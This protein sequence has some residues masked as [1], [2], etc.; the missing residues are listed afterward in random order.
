M[1]KLRVFQWERR[2]DLFSGISKIMNRGIV[3][4][5]LC[6]SVVK[7]NAQT[8]TGEPAAIPPFPQACCAEP[9]E[10]P[11]ITEINRQPS[12]VTAYSY[13]NVADAIEDNREKS[14]FLLLN[15][16]WN[17]KLVLK[18]AD[19]PSDFFLSKVNNWETIDVPSNWEMKG[20]DKPIY[21]SS[22]YPF[23]PIDPPY[24]PKDYNAVGSYQRTFTVPA[25]W[26]DMT[27]TLHFGGVSSG[28]KVW[29]N[30]KFVGYGED[31]CLPS[32]FIVNPYL[33]DGENTVSVQVIR[34]A[35]GVYLEDQDHWRMSG[36][37]REVFLMAEP[38]LRIADFFWQAKLDKDYK[39]A[40]LSIRP[41]LENLTGDTVRGCFIKAQLYD[42]NNN[43]VLA[44]PLSRT[45]E[46]LINEFYPRLDN[47]KFGALET[48]IKNPDKWSDEAPNL[49]TLV[50]T[51]ED[52][53][54]RIL[55]TKS[56]KVGFRSI[57]FSKKDS[58]LLINGKVTY[59]Y[60]IN[61]HDHNPVNGKALT[62]ADIEKDVRTIKQFNFNCIRTAHYPN[63]PY[64]YDLCD[65]YGILVMDEANRETHGLG[66]KLNNTDQWIHAIMERTTRMVERDKNHPCVIMW[67][68][69]NE[70]G[71]GPAD[72]AAA[73]WVH[74]FDITRPVHYEPAQGS[75]AV[76]GYIA[77]GEPG[78]PA[79][80][81]HRIQDP[82]DQYYVDMISR[83]YPGIYT[84]ELLVNQPGDNRPIFFCEYSHSM[85][86]STGNMK[87]FW[88]LFR[89]LPRIIGGCIWDFKD[90]GILKK[91]SAGIEY[92]AY[93]G[94]FGD[95]PNDGNFCINGVA[96]A[97][98]RPK[99]AM[100]ECKWVYQPVYC[101]MVD[102][103]KYL[104]KIT[105]RQSVIS[106][107]GYIPTVQILEDGKIIKSVILPPINIAAGKDTVVSFEKYIPKFKK[108]CEYLLNIKFTAK[109]DKPWASKGFEIASDQFALTGVVT[110]GN[111]QEKY[112][113]LSIVEKDTL[114]QINGKN[115]AIKFSKNNGA[116]SSYV[117]NGSENIFRPL[118]PNFTRPQTDNDHR[119]WKPFKK[120]QFWYNTPVDLVS[121]KTRE[122]KTGIVEVS[123]QYLM[124]G[125]KQNVINAK[126]QHFNVDGEQINTE[127]V[128]KIKSSATVDVVYTIYGNGT[129]KVD[130]RLN[131]GDSLPNIPK[132]GMQCGIR[133]DCDNINWYGRGLWENYIDRRF[134]FESGIWSQNI[135]DFMEP[136]IY[137]Q[138]NGNRTD[139]R[140]MFLSNKQAKGLLVVADSLLSMSAWPYTQANIEAAQHTNKLK[141]A[142]FLTLNIDLIQMGIGGNDTWSD[143]SAPLAQYQVKSKPYHYS[144]YLLPYEGKIEN[145]TPVV[146]SVK[147]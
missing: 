57:E 24:V 99:A 39:D 142:G 121:L 86:N 40:V 144:F 6:S 110:S 22:V 106:T 136:Y 63:D 90:Q 114:V 125:N 131:P 49:Y 21:K 26:K 81:S 65:K 14:R 68:L 109:D 145:I 58:K 60:G 43:P 146:K 138:E 129:V 112:S 118:L 7:L 95:K 32:E 101:T 4:V 107:E 37:Q 47:V 62:R 9:Y 102:L 113:D 79:D 18:P 53:S 25:T 117:T 34:W 132:V 3:S 77:P 33:K 70:A 55:E 111:S 20:Y 120:L 27:I 35:D 56:C 97:D 123:A 29:V 16:K 141:D 87:E 147:K 115:F 17:F 127:K 30:G 137:P 44:T 92:F 28:F 15:G 140:W 50:L 13:S 23:R 72:A 10:D 51:L 52:K 105:N 91:D 36:I 71:R 135:T 122:L 48:K 116:L 19:A 103:Q 143:V 69:G 54:G 89:S 85:G 133:R 1:K 134:G 38:R 82:V 11:L 84:P 83:M 61:R 42:K 8:V 41:R 46:S 75:P 119:G 128:Q 104:L 126:E 5:I 88:D 93:G 124:D 98:G 31:S 78:Y 59:L 76:E 100:Y 66:G 96:A 94:D 2:G 130:Y 108:G 67:S 74:D 64:F 73:A 80:H 139:V 12:R 45:A